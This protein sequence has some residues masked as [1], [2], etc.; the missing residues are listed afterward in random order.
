MTVLGAAAEGRRR[1]RRPRRLP[2]RALGR[3][4]DG[5]RR[6]GRGR[7]HD[8]EPSRHADRAAPPRL[9]RGGGRQA[10][11]GL[12]PRRLRARRAAGRDLRRHPPRL[13]LLPGGG[14]RRRSPRSASSPS[15]PWRRSRRRSSAG[16]SGRAARRSARAPGSS[17]GFVDLGLHAAPSEP[18]SGRACSGPTSSSQRAVRD[19][20]A[21]ADRALRLELPQLTHGVLW[22][23]ALNLLAYV[24]F[25]L[26]A[27]GERRRAAAGEG[28]RRRPTTP[29]VAPSF[30]LFRASV[31]VDDLRATVARYLGEERTNRSFEGFAKSRGGALERTRGGRHPP[32]ALCRA[33]PR[34]GDRRR[35]VAAGAVAA[36]APPQRLDEGDALQAP[37]RRLG[38]DPVQPRP[39]PARARPCP[40]GHHRA[41]PRPSPARLEPRLHRP[42]RAAAGLRARRRRPRRDHPPQRR[43][44]LLRPRRGRG[45]WRRSASTA[46]STTPSRVRVRLHP[47][48]TVI[49]IRSNQLPDGGFVTTYTDVDRDRRGRGG[50]Q[51]RERDSSSSAS[52][53]APRS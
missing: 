28:L 3:D 6:D 2:R 44:R 27:A 21:Q 32:P 15:R 46:S 30:R 1:P 13:R 12:R 16:C 4:R 14:R 17:I 40:P 37:R 22:S 50:A 48:G 42:L 24:G 7:D 9:G 38:G 35:V 10:A 34:L 43:A 19:R 31:T 47:T 49:E 25:S 8:L 51:A 18:R 33:P 23:L 41:R 5:D 26:L 36:A 29:S 53:S 11:A 45:A 39:S 20:A 52:A